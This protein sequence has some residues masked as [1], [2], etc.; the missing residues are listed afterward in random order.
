[1]DTLTA[2]QRH[3]FI[4]ACV[5]LL[6]AGVAWR[7]GRFV[8]PAN[9]I[10]GNIANALDE[11]ILASLA[12]AMLLQGVA[13]VVITGE[14]E[15]VAV[16]QFQSATESKGS[17]IIAIERVE[18]SFAPKGEPVLG[19]VINYVELYEQL[20]AKDSLDSATIELIGDVLSPIYSALAISPLIV[21]QDRISQTPAQALMIGAIRF[22]SEVEL[23]RHNLRYGLNQVGD[24]LADGLSIENIEWEW[25]EEWM[26]RGPCQYGHIYQVF[27]SKGIALGPIKISELGGKKLAVEHGLLSNRSYQECV[28]TY[29][30]Q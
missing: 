23:L 25:N 29:E 28:A 13:S 10:P 3:D 24:V 30:R 17:T 16:S 8:A 11:A 15:H 27:L 19:R 6:C 22:Q 4:R 12:K 2:Y 1:M 18:S 7:G 5:D 20:L 26:P 9:N 14:A 21:N